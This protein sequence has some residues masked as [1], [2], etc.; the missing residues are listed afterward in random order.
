MQ[1]LNPLDFLFLSLEK[2]QQPMHVAGLFLFKLPDQAKDT[3][4]K[5]LVEN[6]RASKS[7][8]VAPFNQILDG[9]FWKTDELFDLDHHFRHIS[10]PAPSGLV[11]L[12]TYV[13]QEHSAL[14]D[15]AKPLWSCHIIEGLEGNRFAMYFKVH[16]S[17]IDGIAALRL[18]SKSL[19]F[20]S[21]QQ[22][23]V[24]PWAL[25]HHEVKELSQQIKPS[26]L[27]N[28]LQLAKKQLQ[29][30]PTAIK[31]ITQAVFSER[32]KHPDYVSTSQAPA[33]ILNQR[34]TASRR[35]SAMSYDL[36]RLK[37]I[38]STLNATLNDIIL[39]LCAGA[40]R[41]YLINIHELPKRPLI[42]MVPAS[43]RHDDSAHGNQITMILAN[44]ATHKDT[45]LERLRIIQR[46]MQHTKQR[47]KRM[48]PQQIFNYSAMAYGLTGLNVLSGLRPKSQAFNLIISNVPG[49]Q[50]PMY[51]N[52]ALMENLY[53]VSIVL[54]GQA[55]NI[56][57]TTYLQQLE[58]GI[59]ACR[60][61]V[62]HVQ[63]ILQYFADEIEAF[64]YVYELQAKN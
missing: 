62:P 14:L 51:W 8:P 49:P 2:R 59:V 45:P 32:G 34:I 29:A 1:A 28:T 63:T 46:S 18:L 43:L 30:T 40:I 57:M 50:Q 41:R 3:Y 61:T 19:S 56:T 55:V 17:L 60:R 42:A 54:D 9:V 37:H 26:L 52:G 33:T 35:F 38:A 44:L 48:T 20:D 21:Q 39:A 53:P 47:F 25:P 31:E 58:V 10:L 15:R 23:I 5:D 6:I 12:Y 24:A 36:A 16:H 11:E 27:K 22:S 13:S 7:I 64:E 4:V